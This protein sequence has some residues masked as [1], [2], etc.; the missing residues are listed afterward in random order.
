MSDVKRTILYQNHVELGGNMVEFAGFE[1]PLFYSNITEEHHAVRNNVGMFDVSH[2]GEILVTGKDALAFVNHICTN[3]FSKVA[4]NKLNYTLFC[5]EDG[6][7]VD[8]SMVYRMCENEFLLVVNAS[9]L[10]KDYEWIV[11][12]TNGF[13]VIVENVSDYYGQIALQGPLA[14]AIFQQMVG[15]DLSKILFLEF[16][17]DDVLGQKA[18]VSRSG[19]TGEDGFE[20]YAE[21]NHIVTIWNHLIKRYHVTPCGLGCRDTLRF[22]AALPLYGHEIDATINPLEAGLGFAVKLDKPE[23]IGKTALADQKANGLKRK[24]VGIELLE[25]NIPRQGYPV[26]AN[27]EQI[28]VITTGYLS[29]SSGLPVANALISPSFAKIGTNVFVQIRK[30][31]VPAVVRDRKFYNKK[32]KK[33][34]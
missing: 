13:D 25:R 2:M 9:N 23:F 34:E 7:C 21:K 16:T 26:F 10:E 6:G 12:Q 14:E 1:M 22:E 33:G 20:I 29:P 31:M 8:D 19:Y 30:K 28:G 32:Y 15:F 11:N 24:M 27:D 18:I 3:D 4:I 5:Y 17:F